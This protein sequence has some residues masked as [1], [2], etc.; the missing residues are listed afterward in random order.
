MDPLRA[1]V[2]LSVTLR[3]QSTPDQRAEWGQFFTPRAVAELMAAMVQVPAG[4][5]PFRILDPGAGTGILG[6]AA[7]VRVLQTTDR[8]VRLVAVEA[9]PGA[10]GSLGGL[11]D[12]LAEAFPG[13]VTTELLEGDFLALAER[14]SS[15]DPVDLAIANPPYFKMSPSDRRGGD[16]PN[17]YARFMEVAVRL[18][19]PRGQAV[20]IVPRSFASGTYFHRFRQRLHRRAALLDVHVFESRRD[21]FREEGVLQESVIVRYGRHTQRPATVTITTSHG[22]RDIAE[23]TSLVVSSA[24]VLRPGDPREVLSLPTT[25]E[26]LA[27]LEH[28]EGWPETLA[29]LGLAISTGPVVPFRARSELLLDPAG[30]ETAPLLWM[31]HVRPGRVTWPLPRTFEKSQHI[32][33]EAPSKLLVPRGNYVL[34]RR[35]SA[36][37]DRRR[38]TAALLLATEVPSAVIGLENHLNY[39]HRPSGEL[40]PEE[41]AG[42]SVLLGSTVLDRTFRIS[43]GNTQVSASEIRGL[44]L[45]PREV[46]EG[47]GERWLADPAR[48]FDELMAEAFGWTAGPGGSA[49]SP[50]G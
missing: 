48:D 41:A 42:L 32:R 13:R 22:A 20:F 31:N 28:L 33:V 25:A 7:A 49:R 11:L 4:T 18:L 10:L 2:S 29:S 50:M 21:V 8:S 16:A 24:Q 44:P 5:G 39:I 17:I 43:S 36:K 1:A 45:P 30:V 14:G 9:E 40:R 27:L 26:D 12:A 23:R 37:E 19:V 6:L 46:I 35:F 38:L 47:L 34:L 15:L 3:E